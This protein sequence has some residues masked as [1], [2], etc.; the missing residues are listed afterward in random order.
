MSSIIEFEYCVCVEMSC[1]C[2]DWL[3]E[4]VKLF[5]VAPNGWTSI[6]TCAIMLSLCAI[7]NILI[8]FSFRYSEFEAFVWIQFQFGNILQMCAFAWLDIVFYGFR[9]DTTDIKTAFFI[10]STSYYIIVSTNP[11]EIGSHWWL[12]LM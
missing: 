11:N 7:H 8:F 1:V 12:Y 10:C 5:S 4:I 3:L 2:F 9:I 6:C